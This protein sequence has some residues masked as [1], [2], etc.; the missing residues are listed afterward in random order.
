MD[1]LEGLLYHAFHQSKQTTDASCHDT[2]RVIVKYS[3]LNSEQYNLKLNQS[4]PVWN[5]NISRRELFVVKIFSFCLTL[6][7]GSVSN[8]W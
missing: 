8:A 4:W 3:T 1:I 7:G 6:P 5:P 2:L